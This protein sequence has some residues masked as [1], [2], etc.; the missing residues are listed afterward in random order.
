MSAIRLRQHFAAVRS[1]LLQQRQQLAVEFV[2][3][4]V[5]ICDVLPAGIENAE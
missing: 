4:P 3:V 2:A 5:F 1:M